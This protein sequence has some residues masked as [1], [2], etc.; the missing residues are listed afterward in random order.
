MHGL[1]HPFVIRRNG[2]LVAG[3]RR[4]E[5]CRLLGWIETPARRFDDLTEDELREMEFDE[6]VE[7]VNLISYELRKQRLAI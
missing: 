5:A 1:L 7:R 3:Q 6:N 2:E 4:L